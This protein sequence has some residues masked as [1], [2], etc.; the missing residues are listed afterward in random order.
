MKTNANSNFPQIEGKIMSEILNFPG[1]K[2]AMVETSSPRKSEMF[3]FLV[4]KKVD[5]NIRTESLA[6]IGSLAY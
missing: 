3:I 5:M 1:M 2:P 4:I 6:Y